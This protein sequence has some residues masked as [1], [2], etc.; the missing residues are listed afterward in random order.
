[1]SSKKIYR[2]VLSAMFLALALVL[3]SL[4]GQIRE[5]GKMLCPMHIPILLCGFFCGPWY[6]LAIGIMAPLL[7]SFMFS[8]PILFPNA[9]AMSFEL[10]AYGMFAAFFY[11]ILPKK[12]AYIYVAL[13]GAMLAGRAVWGV[14]SALLYGMAGKEYGMTAF[15]SGAFINALPGII[16]Q[17]VLVPIIVMALGRFTIKD[18][19]KKK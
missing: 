18:E 11:K 8:Q 13:A 4:T 10:A 3:P 9:V 15:I 16:I 5:I 12:K 6:A 7:R 2:M 17:L 1:M 14:V 19:D